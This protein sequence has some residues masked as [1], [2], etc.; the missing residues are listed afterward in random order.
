MVVCWHELG[1][2][3]I[4]IWRRGQAYSGIVTTRHDY[5]EDDGIVRQAEKRKLRLSS[6]R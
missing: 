5:L 6:S 1:L 3:E 2:L 4:S